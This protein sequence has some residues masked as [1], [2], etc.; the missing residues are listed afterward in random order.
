MTGLAAGLP[1][2]VAAGVMNASFTLP[3]K[4]TQRWAWENTWLAWSVFALVLLPP[5][6]ALSTIPHIGAVYG[7]T[8]PSL[9]FEVA[10][11]GAGW[12]VAQVFFGLAV[13]AIGIALTF[14][15]V[16]GTS[17][18]VGTLIPLLRLHPERVHSH[19]GH[20][21]FVGV[22]LVIAGVL[23]CAIAGKRREDS[24]QAKAAGNKKMLLGL[25]LA[26]LCGFGASF[27]NFGLTFGSSLIQTAR[28]FGAGALA[29]SNA[30][31]MPLMMAGAVPNVLYCN[32]LLRRNHSASR[33]A[34]AGAVHWL[35]ALI[36][37]VF[38][39]GSTVLYGIAAAEL[40]SWGAILGWPLFMSL[41]VIT[42]SVLGVLSG[43]WKHSGGV[44]IA[45][46]WVG[47]V[48]LVLAVFVLANMS[49]ALS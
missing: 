48:L 35:L 2:L 44:P 49:R 34:G 10:G 5:L 38:W 28:T 17:A 20:K 45:L 3:M 19:L 7:A 21:V 13:D 4:Y 14:S 1:I 23:V 9:I 26:V 32:L 41:I 46:Q 16:L 39:F 47:V 22:A 15:I 30:V 37:A 42:A 29:A 8:A 18:A 6:L 25:V 40:G 12:G 27:V 24:L 43:E 36:M 11:F 31:W 33:F